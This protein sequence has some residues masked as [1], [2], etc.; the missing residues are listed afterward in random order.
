[1]QPA[2]LAAVS[3]LPTLRVGRSNPQ[4]W[5]KVA[6]G[7]SLCPERPPENR[8]GL[9]AHPGGVPEFYGATPI[10]IRLGNGRSGTPA[11]VLA[12]ERRIP[13]VVQ[14]K[15]GTTTGYPLAT[16]RVGHRESVPILL[17]VLLIL[18]IAFSVL[19]EYEH[20]DDR[21]AIQF[22]SR[23]TTYNCSALVHFDRTNRVG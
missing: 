16:L 13:V 4:G 23:N 11:G 7:R 12:L 6:G 1:M 21:S 8:V 15:G 20:D 3:P 22:A 2:G 14:G 18:V 9:L 17:L 5:Q 10:S 19:P